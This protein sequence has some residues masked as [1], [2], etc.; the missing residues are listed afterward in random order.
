MSHSRKV[1][2]REFAEAA[3]AALGN[4]VIGGDRS[5]TGVFSLDCQHPRPPSAASAAAETAP[6]STTRTDPTR[7]LSL[8]VEKKVPE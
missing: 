6:V 3:A 8:N 7:D 5:S 1:L 2:T 4:Y